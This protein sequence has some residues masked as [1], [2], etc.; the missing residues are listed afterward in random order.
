ML[1]HT[2]RLTRLLLAGKSNYLSSTTKPVIVVLLLIAGLLF[3][4]Q[5]LSAQ[6][7]DVYVMRIEG[8]VNQAMANYFE[9]GIE[10]AEDVNAEA[11]MIVLDT[12]GGD[13]SAMLDIVRLFERADVPVVVWIGPEGA[14]AAS[15]GSII[16]LA[17]H[18]AGM[19]PDT[20][21]GA[22]SPVTG[23]GEDINETLY[24]KIVEDLQAVARNLSEGRSEEASRLAEE[25]IES[26]EAVTA[27]EA[28]DV[29]FIDAIASNESDL[30]VQIDG[31]KI[32]V[33]ETVV[34][35]ETGS[36]SL[37]ELPQTSVEEAL[38]FLASIL[39]NPIFLSA[40][41]GLGVQAIIFE[42]SNPGGWVGGFI[43]FLCIGLALYGLGQLPTNYL[44]LGLIFVA[45]ILLILELL[46]PT[47]GALAATGVVTMVIGFL[48]LFNSPGTPEF[49]RISIPGA[50]TVA[51]LSAG[52]TL[53]IMAAGLAAQRREP[54]TGE[55]GLVGRVGR[56]RTA[57]IEDG[58]GYSGT[59]F[60]YGS[61]WQ[62]ESSE[63]I[64]PDQKVTV[65]EVDGMRLKVKKV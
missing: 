55:E 43:G 53:A 19:A 49:A 33:N 32:L 54:I 23:S 34:I 31:K 40:L 46:T 9:R 20:V 39:M 62:A 60:V 50:I 6:G 27:S 11:V 12:P 26:A 38:Y 21:V 56:A 36:A 42:F 5:S 14:Q 45:F 64:E 57:L 18:A 37:R 16:L 52:L 59:V 7:A 41:I 24:R 29:G 63:P 3:S 10:T 30:L 22:A 8:P 48:I 25:M 35:L 47:Y 1:K 15:A 17:A 44:G 58:D 51:V 13:V 2:K 65:Q 61:L 4:V 28:L